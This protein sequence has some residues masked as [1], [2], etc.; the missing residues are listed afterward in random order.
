VIV[1]MQL[2]GT[3]LEAPSDAMEA[4]LTEFGRCPTTVWASD[5][6]GTLLVEVGLDALEGLEVD[7][8]ANP[9]AFVVRSGAIVAAS[10][11]P[12]IA[13]VGA[14]T[15]LPASGMLAVDVDWVASMGDGRQAYAWHARAEEVVLEEATTNGSTQLF[16]LDV[17][18]VAVF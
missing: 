18:G 9:A 7:L 6:S 4:R 16:A 17:Y 11:A 12:Q 14:Q 8:A 13:D 2:S 3:P 1:Q 5:T 10:C 15:W